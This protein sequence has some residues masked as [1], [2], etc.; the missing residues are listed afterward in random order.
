MTAIPSRH[1]LFSADFY[2]PFLILLTGTLFFR[3]TDADL[4]IQRW[5]YNPLHAWQ[6]GEIFLFKF[7]YHYGNIPALLVAIT[8][9]LF[10][11][12]GYSKKLQTKNNGTKIPLW[13]PCYRKIHAY[14]V[15]V[16]ILGPGIIVNTILKENW[17][18]P[19]PRELTEFGGKYE[20]EPLLVLDPSSSGKSF[21]CGHATVGYYFFALWFILRRKNRN[22]G[23]LFLILATSYGTLIG[24]AR[25]AQGGHFASD[26]L[27]AGVLLYLVSFSLFRVLKL[28]RSLY[29]EASPGQAFKSLQLW[30]KLSL[31]L[32][33]LLIIL[34]VLLATPYRR[35]KDYRIPVFSNYQAPVS[36]QM[37]L[38]KGDISIS[39][40]EN[41]TWETTANRQ[42]HLSAS[43]S[44][45][46]F[47]G[48]KIRNKIQT[49]TNPSHQS[50]QMNQKLSGFF[51]ELDASYQLNLNSANSYLLNF[52]TS[53]G[54]IVID[55][56]T[57]KQSPSFQ[58][59]TQKGDIFVT[60]PK[61]FKS[62][63]VIYNQENIHNQR[64]DLR[65]VPVPI[66]SPDSLQYR[67]LSPNGKI[68]LR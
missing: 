16:M 44:G 9:L 15:L 19:R 31:A 26:V 41:G 43:I 3:L 57:I 52:K 14:L 20:Y 11:A 28:D 47:P 68:H 24:L 65:L 48:S 58:L 8:S 38:I 45:F 2:L 49:N 42:P 62:P 46:G 21:P 60:F 66:A 30:Q 53:S 55:S 50:W 39:S 35:V 7:V 17:G 22:I 51:S 40:I 5:F 12:L 27:W 29:Y 34:G 32:I 18:R 67:F 6:T 36:M 23:I 10:F 25:I 33:G 13:H 4:R 61:Q 37:E 1:F 63:I 56:L 64:P 54:D 59:E